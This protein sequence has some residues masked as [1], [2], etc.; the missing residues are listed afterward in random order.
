MTACDHHRYHVPPW[1][2]PVVLDRLGENL[3]DPV[4]GILEGR[5]AY[6]D[7]AI[8]GRWGGII[9]GDKVTV[10]MNPCPCGRTGPTIIEV[11]RYA[12]L[13]E[14]DDKLTCAGTIDAYVRGSIGG[15]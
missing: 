5:M 14:G 6:L 12:D 13:D 11:A 8:A 3:V 10:D 1:V 7:L 2:I 15:P 9:S 4:G